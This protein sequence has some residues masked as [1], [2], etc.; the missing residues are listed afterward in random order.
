[1][2]EENKEQTP[3]PKILDKYE[4]EA[5]LD[6]GL[7]ERAKE[8]GIPL[9]KYETL[10]G[11]VDAYRKL[12]EVARV[13]REATKAAPTV[14]DSKLPEQVEDDFDFFKTA[15]IDPQRFVS[16]DDLTDAEVQESLK[17]LRSAVANDKTGRVLFNQMREV[18]R[19]ASKT[20][21][22]VAT[23]KQELARTKT[24]YAVRDATGLDE[25]G[26]TDLLAR[27]ND[28]LEESERAVV[29]RML[30]KPQSEDEILFGVKMVFERAKAKGMF[31]D[32]GGG[33]KQG[34][35][36]GSPPSSSGE[37]VLSVKEAQ[38]LRNRVER[39]DADAKA[40]WSRVRIK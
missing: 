13:K 5:D 33:N 36:S 35:I 21:L 24:K 31:A 40:M 11:K 2:P 8:V 26:M 16:D 22:E 23:T 25:K 17:A 1:M 18:T 3:Q 12:S 9:G 38:E 27:R 6:K 39:G 29:D 14:L 34:I 4:T 10:E 20:K 15:K 19:E 32:L 7:E 28:F 30:T 37:L